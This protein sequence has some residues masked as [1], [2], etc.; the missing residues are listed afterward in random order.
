MYQPPLLIIPFIVVAIAGG[1]RYRP[2]T[3]NYLGIVVENNS[4]CRK[5]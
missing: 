5:Q 3:L 4:C 1:E 2:A